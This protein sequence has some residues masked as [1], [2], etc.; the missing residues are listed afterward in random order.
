MVLV[1]SPDF[2]LSLLLDHWGTQSKLPV[3]HNRSS[4]QLSIRISILLS[5]LIDHNPKRSKASGVSVYRVPTYLLVCFVSRPT[6]MQLLSFGY[7]SQPFYGSP[8]RPHSPNLVN[9]RQIYLQDIF[10]FY[11]SFRTLSAGAL[12]P[13]NRATSCKHFE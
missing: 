8:N 9:Y 7:L 6:L 12:L 5:Q 3:F 1:I 11:F 13:H 10:L 4:N 2:S